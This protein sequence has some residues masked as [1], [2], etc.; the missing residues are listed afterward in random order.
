MRRIEPTLG[1]G[2]VLA[3][4][5]HMDPA[6][7]V[8]G[9]L[10]DD[11]F[12]DDAE[13]SPVARGYSLRAQG[14]AAL[15]LRDPDDVALCA[16]PP[17]LLYACRAAALASVATRALL[18]PGSATASVCGDAVR[19][20]VMLATLAHCPQHISHIE[21]WAPEAVPAE[22]GQQLDEAGIG[23]TI[24]RRQQDT[25]YGANLLVAASGAAQLSRGR[26]CDDAVLINAGGSVVSRDITRR[27]SAV[28]TDADL[29]ELIT[30]LA[31]A[32]PAGLVLMELLGAEHPDI[33]LAYRLYR[34]LRQDTAQESPATSSD[35]TDAQ[36]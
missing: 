9:G 5:R 13:D 36:Y 28:F 8:I 29:G 27:V 21:A 6:A 2:D 17:T 25:V 16:F 35:S 3:A 23:L 4:L 33:A 15:V 18:P 24:A 22:A 32:R 19:V 10:F 12:A 11:V 1:I 14:T 20:P 31:P 7:G 26:L 34:A 30:G